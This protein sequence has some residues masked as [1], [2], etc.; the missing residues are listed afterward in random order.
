MD[1]KPNDAEYNK[2]IKRLNILHPPPPPRVL[3]NGSGTGFT[4]ARGTTF[5]ICWTV[6]IRTAG[7]QV[8]VADGKPSVSGAATWLGFDLRRFTLPWTASTTLE[9]SW[10][11][12][13]VR[14]SR[15][16]DADAWG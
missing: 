5:E 10:T 1:A 16:T 9:I 13:I 11:I 8:V 4:T 12:L 6:G 2:L 14:T 3:V 7:D 15:N